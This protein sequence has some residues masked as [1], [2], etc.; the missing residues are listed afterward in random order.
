LNV[1]SKAVL[2][3]K[4]SS[5]PKPVVGERE[6]NDVLQPMID[7]CRVADDAYALAGETT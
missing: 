1:G 3:A 5:D 7:R 6:I 4:E 2:R